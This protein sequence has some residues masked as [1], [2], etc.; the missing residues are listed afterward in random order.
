MP[1]MAS[2]TDYRFDLPPLPAKISSLNGQIVDT[3][4]PSWHCSHDLSS[5]TRTQTRWQ[6]QRTSRLG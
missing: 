2:Q 1:T 6:E 3:N 5:P 4:Q